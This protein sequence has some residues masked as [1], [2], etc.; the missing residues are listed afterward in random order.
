[1][2]AAVHVSPV[3]G[4]ITHSITAVEVTATG[5]PAND[6]NAY[7]ILLSPSEPVI[8]YYFKFAKSGQDSLISPEF[9]PSEAGAAEWH[10]VIVPAAGTWTLTLNDA[11]DDTVK[12]TASVVVA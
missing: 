7:N 10:D 8:N 6:A 9:G 1:M 3:S 4:S 2:V 5:A 11:S 12:A